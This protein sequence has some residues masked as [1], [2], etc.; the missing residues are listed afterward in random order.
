[1]K[2]MGFGETL[3]VFLQLQLDVGSG[4]GLGKQ[5]TNTGQAFDLTVQ[6]RVYDEVK[7]QTKLFNAL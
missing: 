2:K 7:T 5:C 6:L 1:M 4:L 3:I